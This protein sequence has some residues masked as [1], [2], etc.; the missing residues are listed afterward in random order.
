MTNDPTARPPNGPDDGRDE[1]VAALLA[2]AP[3]DEHTRARLV[4]RALDEVPAPRRRTVLVSVAA[5]LLVVVVA[6]T[7]LLTSRGGAPPTR[8]A[9]RAGPPNAAAAPPGPA[10]GGAHDLG[11][12]GDVTD[13]ARLRQVLTGPATAPGPSLE[14]IHQA[15]GA[16]DRIAGVAGID[17]VATGVDAGQPVAVLVG[18]DPR[19]RRLA[20][21]VRLAGCILVRRVPLP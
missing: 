10:E 12:V 7:V 1:R 16:G 13:P 20:V 11:P 5:A 3:L 19:G 4:R 8:A 14:L 6:G 18:R 21:V 9:R 15:C 17:T 2:V